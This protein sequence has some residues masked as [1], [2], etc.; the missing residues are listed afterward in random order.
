MTKKKIEFSRVKLYFS[1][2]GSG[3]S[4]IVFGHCAWEALSFFTSFS[5]AGFV[6][7]SHFKAAGDC[8]NEK[9][10]ILLEYEFSEKE[11][12]RSSNR[13]SRKRH[14]V[15]KTVR[16]QTSQVT[17]LSYNLAQNFG[18]RPS[19]I[20][21][22]DKVLR[23]WLSN[24]QFSDKENRKFGPQISNFPD[25]PWQELHGA[26]G[27]AEQRSGH[28][29]AGCAEGCKRAEEW[30]VGEKWLK[31]CE[32]RTALQSQSGA[33]L[34]QQAKYCGAFAAVIPASDA[35]FSC[36]RR[37]RPQDRS[38]RVGRFMRVR[39]EFFENIWLLHL[40]EDTCWLLSQWDHSGAGLQEHT[41]YRT[42]RRKIG[43]FEY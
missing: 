24:I 39:W 7:A 6:N 2:P 18:F 32:E 33:S 12:Q 40:L 11:E 16:Q 28:I 34:F 30:K 3:I 23:F 20:Q 42:Y 43:L 41:W 26:L 1:L 19:N 5:T 9:R 27:R 25:N 13:R 15:R 38:E 29:A 4:I 37:R 14:E 10:E 35:I 22:A 36:S 17:R 21:F 31:C 8:E